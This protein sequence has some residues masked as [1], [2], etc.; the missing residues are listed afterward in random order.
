[1]FACLVHDDVAVQV[2]ELALGAG[3]ARHALEAPHGHELAKR[4]AEVLNARALPGVRAVPLVEQDRL[5]PARRHE[6]ALGHGLGA[7]VVA[8]HRGRTRRV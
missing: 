5:D 4:P 2:E 1:L 3:P 8:G 7:P 6:D